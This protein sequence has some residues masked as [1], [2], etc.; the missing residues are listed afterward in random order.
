LGVSVI[1]ILEIQKGRNLDRAGQD[2]KEYGNR[3]G[4]FTTGFLC[5]KTGGVSE[6]RLEGLKPGVF[7]CVRRNMGVNVI[8]YDINFCE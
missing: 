6:G 8:N 3:G 7:A 4:G 5:A 1:G 2:V